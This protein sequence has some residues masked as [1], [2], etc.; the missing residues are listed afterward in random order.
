MHDHENFLTFREFEAFLL[1]FH[2]DRENEIGFIRV[3]NMP[4]AKIIL[5][6]DHC[7]I[8]Y[9]SGNSRF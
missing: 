6:P 9:L 3:Y 5:I 2:Q 4:Y 1:E 8:N 7:I